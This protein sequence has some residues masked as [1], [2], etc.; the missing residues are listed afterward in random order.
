[1]TDPQHEPTMEEI[2]A[3]IRK[4]ISDDANDA[5]PAPVLPVGG[6]TPAAEPEVLELTQE[7]HETQTA[8]VVSVPDV[9]IPPPPPIPDVAP[10]PPIYVLPQS[11]EE[12]PVSS[13]AEAPV[14]SSEGIFSDK[15]RKALD[16]TFASLEPTAASAGGSTAPVAPVDGPTV[17]SA[18]DRAV[19]ETF[20]P[21]LQKWLDDHADT[22]IERMKPLIGEWLDEH[23]PVMLEDAVRGE[24]ARV[25]KTRGRR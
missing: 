22:I 5:Q 25:A 9:I 15:S 20:E 18:F 17:T 8:T 16:E 2:L 21:V 1:M 13:Q 4:I 6:A 11:T 19:R 3:S 7:V 14:H 12:I 10:T 24:V 23:F